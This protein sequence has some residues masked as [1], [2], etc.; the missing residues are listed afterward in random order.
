[1]RAMFTRW[2]V[3]L[4]AELKLL[5]DYFSKQ[6]PSNTARSRYEFM[7]TRLDELEI[8]LKTNHTSVLNALTDAAE[9]Q[10]QNSDQSVV[11]GK[12]F[13]L[14][15]I[16]SDILEAIREKEEQAALKQR[17]VPEGSINSLE[18]LALDTKNSLEALHSLGRKSHLGEDL[19]VRLILRKMD[20]DS[21]REFKKSLPNKDVPE[22]TILIDFI[23]K[24]VADHATECE[25]TPNSKSS[26]QPPK[27]NPAFNRPSQ[28]S[29]PTC[30]FCKASHRNYECEKLRAT[31]VSDR[32]S[33]A[34]EHKDQP[35]PKEKASSNN[36]QVNSSSN[37]ILATAQIQVRNKLDEM[38][39]CRALIDSGSTNTFIN[40]SMVHT[41]G[42]HKEKLP[43]ALEV[44]GLSDV[45]IAT[46][47]HQVQL[48]ISCSYSPDTLIS[49]PALVVERCSGPHPL[50]H[51]DPTNWS[52]LKGLEL[53]DKEF[54]TRKS[55]D[56]LVGADIYPRIIRAGIIKG[57]AD[58]PMAQDSAFGWIVLGPTPGFTKNPACL[59]TS[60]CLEFEIKKFWEIEEVPSA[61]QSLTKEEREWESNFNSTTIR[62][63][64]GS[65]QVELPFKKDQ[66]PLRNSK[67]MA[68]RWFYNLESKLEKS[69]KLKETYH[70]QM[71]NLIKAGHVEAVR[72]EKIKISESSVYYLPHH[73]VIKESSSTT[74][75][76]IVFDASAKS[77]SG[78]SLNDQ[79]MVGPVCQEDLF[80]IL[81]RFRWWKVPMTAD[82]KEMY[83]NIWMRESHRNFQRIYW[84]FT[85]KEN[86]QTFRLAKV[87]FGESCAPAQAIEALRKLAEIY[88][89]EF[90]EAAK[91]LLRDF[92]V[93][94]CLTGASS[95][96]KAISLQS[97]LRQL[98]EKGHFNLRKWSSADS[99]VLE[100][101]PEE[102]RETHLPLNLDKD[103][104]IKA[105][106]LIWNPGSD[107]F[108]FKVQ[109]PK[110]SQVTKRIILSEISRVF[111]PLGLLAPVTIRAKT[112]MR[113]L[114][115]A[116]I[117][118]DSSPPLDIKSDWEEYQKDVQRIDALR[119]PRWISL[120]DVISQELHGFSDASTKAY[121]AAVYLR[122]ISRSAEVSVKLIASKSRVAP[123]KGTS[124]PR[125]ELCAAELLANLMQAIQQSL[126][127]EFPKVYGW[128][129]STDPNFIPT[130][131]HSPA[132]E[133][134]PE[135]PK[136]FAYNP[137]TASSPQPEQF[138][139][140]SA[141]IV[142]AAMICKKQHFLISKYSS[143]PKLIRHTAWWLRIIHHRRS[144]S[145]HNIVGSILTLPE[146]RSAR[147]KL[148]LL[149]Q[150]E[151]LKK[152][153][154]D[155]RSG[156][157]NPKSPHYKL[158]PWIDSK[159]GL[160]KAGGRLE[161]AK[162][163]EEAHSSPTP[164][165]YCYYA[166]I[167]AVSTLS[168][169]GFIAALRRFVARRGRPSHIFSDNGTN[170]VSADKEL[171]EIQAILTS[172]EFN[173]AVSR[174]LQNEEIEWQ[175]NPPSAQHMGGLW[176]S[177]V[178]STKF[179]LKRVLGGADMTFDEL[180]T[181]LTQ[182][183]AALNSR[184]LCPDSTHPDEIAAITPGHF[185]IGGPL[186]ALPDPDLKDPNVKVEEIVIIMEDNLPPQKWKLA[187]VIEVH[188]NPADKKNLIRSVTV[189][190]ADGTFKRPI[191]KLCRIP[192]EEDPELV[193]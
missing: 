57:K 156:N 20:S 119:I 100:S 41:L 64:D 165:S 126:P 80:S 111:D 70:A 120:Q 93:D 2:K 137:S 189:K 72:S 54:H 35:K 15:C 134:P 192:M 175:F 150:E 52:H 43:Q 10:S 127:E 146:I 38:W 18:S 190:T 125:L 135:L 186:L 138:Q 77:T 69:P 159:D 114:W 149:V 184:P 117:R 76:R 171:K 82:I 26:S 95:T 169:E 7:H 112:L 30:S 89:Q 142:C 59:S 172:K 12:I 48:E 170:F 139:E 154:D 4:L 124:I 87:T 141:P 130:S 162:I 16:L 92:Y 101:I 91:V 155:I 45:D 97:E 3:P 181:A 153:F 113:R 13:D 176:E 39:N 102:F 180:S 122:R 21:R 67:N 9:I 68:L 71:R 174:N 86:I 129:D 25:K 161:N 99:E 173:T 145:N 90:P 22:L 177:A 74:K 191:T 62:R 46:V 61:S 143:F 166:H 107:Q 151:A 60:C 29:T 103:S 187:R 84:R 183:E 105:L 34:K 1:M 31:Q 85:T 185:L 128:T 44:K 106:G 11:I 51:V 167:E 47:T 78:Q 158:S 19:V 108:Q 147:R 37:T 188:N 109:L 27:P 14:R 55:V 66:A 132:V 36:S 157:V 152:E 182:I 136:G 28:S 73:G 17:N 118:W 160:L 23:N 24:V 6:I 123:I 5:Q 193:Q 81:V 144:K 56:I 98:T 8:N 121:A 164:S 63:E 104:A 168:T 110:S 50:Q 94:D 131:R 140:A 58:Q 83:L 116:D 53:A 96:E 65:F 179:H 40:A 163:P 75:L 178:K 49:T 33:F 148:I 79:L 32:L 133:V 88:A 115:T 42:L